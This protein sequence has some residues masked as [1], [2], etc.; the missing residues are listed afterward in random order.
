METKDVVRRFYGGLARQD[1]SWQDDL[2]ESVAFSDASG[3]L[4][5]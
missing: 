3:K 4:N 1:S 2:S 5:A